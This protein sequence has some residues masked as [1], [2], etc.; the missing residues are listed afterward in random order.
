MSVSEVMGHIHLWTA[1]GNTTIIEP[2]PGYLEDTG[3]LLIAAGSAG[4]N[5]VTDARIAALAIAHGAVVHT[6]DRDF[7]RF[8]GCKTV[9]PLDG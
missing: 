8:P 3:R 7:L 4:G 6:C 2:H 9:F 1:R 5:L